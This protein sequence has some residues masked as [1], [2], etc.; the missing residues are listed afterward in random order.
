[1]QFT[2]TS[3]GGSAAGAATLKGKVM[4]VQVIN[5]GNIGANQF[6]LLIP[7]GGVGAMTQGCPTQLGSVNLGATNGGFLSTC[8]GDASC[9]RNM[10][11]T[12]FAGKTDLLN[13][14]LWF[15]DCFQG[16]DNPSFVYSKV[17]CP[18]QLTS[19]SKLSG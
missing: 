10:C 5:I 2:G 1:L 8:S 11:N 19:K 17:T 7:G 9:V 13:G 3:N 6:D 4:I 12:A 16:A 14:C 15:T 18:S